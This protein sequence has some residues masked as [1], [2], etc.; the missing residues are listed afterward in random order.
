MIQDILRIDREHIWVKE[1][2]GVIAL[3]VIA[4]L[5]EVLFG[6]VALYAIVAAYFVSRVGAHKQGRQRWLYMVAVTVL[7]TLLSVLTLF[8]GD[9]TLRAILLWSGIIYLTGLAVAYG[10]ST[11][12]AAYFLVFWVLFAMLAA[13]RS[14]GE[15]TNYAVGFLLGGAI[16]MIIMAIRVRFGWVNDTEMEAT[17]T[18]IPTL[19]EVAKSD[20]GVFAILWALTMAIA[21]LIGYSFWSVE[22]FWVASTLLVV[23]QPDVSKGAKTGIQRGIGSAVGGLLALA[24]IGAFPDFA[25][26]YL[27]LLYFFASVAL[28]V[29]FYRANYM[30]YAFFMTQGVVVYYGLVVGDFT[31]VGG[32]RVFGVL[33]GVVIGL[34]GLGVQHLIIEAR[35]QHTKT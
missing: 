31:E 16:A 8:V 17:S 19:A 28:C 13:S 24:L 15:P 30:I 14:P 9:N 26:S 20:I 22:P 11:F 4:V 27:F 29:T 21:I 23:M 1:G 34:I 18:P 35:K 2:I 32:Q 3:L 10:R 12:Y 25:T 33:L 6:E 5:F 7:G